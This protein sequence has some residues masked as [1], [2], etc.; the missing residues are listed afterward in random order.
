MCIAFTSL[1]D[2]GKDIRELPQQ[3]HNL[4][5]KVIY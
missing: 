2:K 3:N 5:V 4:P 1:D